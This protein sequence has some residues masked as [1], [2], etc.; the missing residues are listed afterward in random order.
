M[1]CFVLSYEKKNNKTRFYLLLKCENEE[2]VK[3]RSAYYLVDN[4]KT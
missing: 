4:R 1:H 2:K 3:G